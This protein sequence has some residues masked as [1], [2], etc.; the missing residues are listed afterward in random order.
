MLGNIFPNNQKWA[1][2]LVT[3]FHGITATGPACIARQAGEGLGRAAI[4]RSQRPFY[5]PSD[6]RYAV[7]Q[8]PRPR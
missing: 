1:M 4:P 7:G 3:R 5:C 8:L 6:I 2:V